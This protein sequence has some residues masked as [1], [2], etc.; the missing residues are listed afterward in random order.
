MATSVKKP[1]RDVDT[2]YMLLMADNGV[3]NRTYD[4]VKH[5]AT[6]QQEHI[7]ET[8]EPFYYTLAGNTLIMTVNHD[9]C[10]ETYVATVD[11]SGFYHLCNDDKKKTVFG[12]SV[13]PD[14]DNQ[15]KSTVNRTQKIDLGE[16]NEE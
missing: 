10:M 8:N 5:T 15:P 9:G 2:P 6:Y 1:I 12:P 11:L 16:D 4:W 7:V 14:E 13:L 3:D